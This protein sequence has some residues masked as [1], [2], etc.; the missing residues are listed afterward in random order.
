MIVSRICQCGIC[1][2]E[3][4]TNKDLL[5]D[6]WAV[7]WDIPYTICDDCL[8]NWKE[9]FGE[10]PMLWVNGKEKELTIF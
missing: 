4:I 2:K 9:R 5:P 6:G 1:G 7:L 3:D 10:E 8:S